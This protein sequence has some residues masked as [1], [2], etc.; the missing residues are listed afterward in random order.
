MDPDGSGSGSPTLDF[1]MLLHTGAEHFGKV[2]NR[3]IL[4][5]WLQLLRLLLIATRYISEISQNRDIHIL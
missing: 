1:L 4:K 3:G 5:T 2:V